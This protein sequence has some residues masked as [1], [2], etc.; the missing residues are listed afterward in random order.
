MLVHRLAGRQLRLQ[1]RKG[2]VEPLLSVVVAEL[3]ATLAHV[4]R[5]A[6]ALAVAV[7][8]IAGLI[9]LLAIGHDDANIVLG[10]LEI[11][12]RE[13][14]IAGRLSIARQGEILLGYMRRG[15]PDFHLRTIGLEAPRERILAFPV[16]AAAAAPILL[17]LPHCLIGS[18]F[19]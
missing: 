6:H 10:V 11:V 14:R 8:G 5:P 1:L 13:H 3:V 2:L 15:A 16:A 7:H 12:F 18:H 4:T 19:T 17:S 9:E